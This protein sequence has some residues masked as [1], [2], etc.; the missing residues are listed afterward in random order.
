MRRKHEENKWWGWYKSGWE[1]R[2]KNLP[3]AEEA[4]AEEILLTCPLCG[5]QVD[6]LIKTLANGVWL[7]V[8]KMCYQINKGA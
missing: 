4:E 5:S 2:W 1:T 8:C 7:P 6:Q 3:P